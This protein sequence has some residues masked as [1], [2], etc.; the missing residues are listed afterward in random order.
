MQ[1]GKVY[2]FM[3]HAYHHFIARLVEITGK[4]E[5][6]VDQVRRVQSSQNQPWTDFFKNGPTESTVLEHFP[7]GE[8]TWFAAFEWKHPIPNKK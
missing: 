8:I 7:D 1:A 6:R 2:Y 5:G 4:R 3:T